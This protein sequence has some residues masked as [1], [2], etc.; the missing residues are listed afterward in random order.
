MKTWRHGN[1]F[2]YQQKHQSLTF[3]IFSLSCLPP[4]TQLSRGKIQKGQTISFI[5]Y[6][7]LIK[8]VQTPAHWKV[9]SFQPSHGNSRKAHVWWPLISNT[10]LYHRISSTNFLSDSLKALS[11]FSGPTILRDRHVDNLL[12]NQLTHLFTLSSTYWVANASSWA[13]QTKLIKFNN[14]IT[15]LAEWQ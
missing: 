8:Y 15:I 13:L 5:W 9:A 11:K 2:P 6:M 12:S 3:K 4:P 7:K 14:Y 1:I 10:L